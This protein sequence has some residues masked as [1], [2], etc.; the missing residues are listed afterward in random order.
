MP[1]DDK[2]PKTSAPAVWKQWE[3]TISLRLRFR[4]INHTY[5][6][7]GLVDVLMIRSVLLG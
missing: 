5:L 4:N 1:E 6:T 2:D 7:E 3:N